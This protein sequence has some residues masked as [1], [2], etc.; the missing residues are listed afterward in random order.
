MQNRASPSP[1][2]NILRDERFIQA[3]LQI[4]FALVV[5]TVFALI[6]VS[7]TNSLQEA[8]LA[9]SFSY[10]NNRAGF[11]IGENP[12]WYTS[13]NTF[14]EAFVV[15]LIN[16]LRIVVVGLVLAT[17]I[18][19]FVGIFLLS[20]NFLLRTIA[21]VY[22]EILRNTPLAV[23]LTVWYFIVMFS[24][25]VVQRSLTF[26]NESVVFLALRWLLYPL[27]VWLI[28]S[29][30]K[31]RLNWRVAVMT[32]AAAAF[33]IEGG[34]WLAARSADW[35]AV[36]GKAD[37]L[38]PVF[39]FYV[40]AS[41]AILAAAWRFTSPAELRELRRPALGI[42]A[43]QL[44]GGL[45]LYF[46]LVPLTALR[47]EVYPLI[48]ANNRGFVFPQILTTGRFNE[49]MAFVIVGIV[50][51]AFIV[52]YFRRVVEQTGKPIPYG[53]YTLLSVIGFALVGWVLVRAE[54]APATIPVDQEG[55]I[56]YLPIAEA[57][58]NDLLTTREEALY[59]RSPLLF[60][61]PERTGLNFRVGLRV[62]PEYMAL[63]LGLA[64]YTSAFIAEIVRAGIQ[65]V[66]Y[67]QVEAARSIGLPYARVL[68]LIVLPQA[69]R[70]IIPPLGNQ[71]LN[72]TK[73]SSLAVLIAFADLFQVTRTI[74]NTSGQSV[75][76]MLMV[77]LTYLVLSL[78]IATG[79]NWFNRRLRF[80]TN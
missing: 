46:N 34:F 52:T 24:L 4:V 78:I 2:L 38:D 70:V 47:V 43:G 40:L 36:P 73:N 71:Y 5:V 31:G 28:L 7:V 27:L 41:L 45:L 75:P 76:G 14:F 63:L 69:L 10:L 13:D 54:P 77:M 8:N 74:M 35:A 65:A 59:S 62:S 49:W 51:A 66:P 53:R 39:L 23:Q 80:V 16:T 1:I 6:A 48:Y 68:R 60:I 17:L 57:R 19:V 29:Y 30:A 22:V 72:L 26:P 61:L 3:V 67:G 9:P 32:V 55:E 37:L 25:P 15:G 12:G 20:S 50:V 21:R 58:S 18:G 79:T 44:V 33:M 56:T 11:D 42:L 64:I